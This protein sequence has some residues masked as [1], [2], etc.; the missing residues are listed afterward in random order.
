[1][2]SSNVFLKN[3]LTLDLL[4]GFY[5]FLSAVSGKLP[6]CKHGLGEVSSQMEGVPVI[7]QMCVGKVSENP[8]L[9]RTK[10]KGGCST[11]DVKTGPGT[12]KIHAVCRVE[13]SS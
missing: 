2:P 7:G 9:Q 4:A 1:M 12:T 11:M 5:P 6:G 8:I 3:Q 13:K 10:L